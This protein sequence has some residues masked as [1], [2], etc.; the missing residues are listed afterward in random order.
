MEAVAQLQGPIVVLGA[1][2]K[3]GP[4]L[5][6]MVKRAAKLAGKEAKIIAVSRFGA[7][8]LR[9]SFHQHGI[10][11]VA[12]DL[13]DRSF[14][15]QLPDAP[16]VIYMV[17]SKFGTATDAPKTWAMNVLV[18]ADICRRYRHSRILAFSTGNVYPLV[19]V[20]SGGSREDDEPAPVGEYAMTALGRERAFQFF[21]AKYGIPTT[22]IRLNYA[23]ELRYGVLLDLAQLVYDQ[24][25][26][27]LSMGYVNVIWQADAAAMALAALARACVPPY[28]LNVAGP[29]ESTT[30][31]IY[32][33]TRNLL[34][35]VFAGA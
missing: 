13:L 20:S 26:I 30:A 23:A 35:R 21:S 22:L 1:G 17:G 4:T 8:S 25:P 14:V 28:V 34:E 9:Q 2:G 11:T 3:M 10:E 16:N 31:G 6:R 5:A 29:R 19:A 7:Q 12:G 33:V 24:Q 27:D 18:P 32:E 15:Q